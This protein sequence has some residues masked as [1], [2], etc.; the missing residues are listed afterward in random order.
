M[1]KTDLRKEGFDPSAVSDRLYYL[2]AKAVEY[3]PI[4]KEVYQN[5]VL[6]KIRL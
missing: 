2:D 1:K 4:D 5:I 3:K 6:G